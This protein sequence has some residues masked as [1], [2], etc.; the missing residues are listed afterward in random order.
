MVA[1]INTRCSLDL[2]YAE[3]WYFHRTSNKLLFYYDVAWIVGIWPCGIFL[4][5]TSHK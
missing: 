3:R 4:R 1:I 5:V 2:C